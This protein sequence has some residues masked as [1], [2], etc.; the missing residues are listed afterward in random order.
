MP[1]LIDLALVR[2]KDGA[3]VQGDRKQ[4][5]VAL[6]SVVRGKKPRPPH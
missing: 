6:E 1:K 3:A 5:A 2:T 4:V